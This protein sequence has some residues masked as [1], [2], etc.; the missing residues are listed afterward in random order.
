MYDRVITGTSSFIFVLTLL[1]I[2]M[3]LFWV[4][5]FLPESQ[6]QLGSGDGGNDSRIFFLGLHRDANPGRIH[7][8][9]ARSEQVGVSHMNTTHT[10]TL[11]H[12]HAALYCGR[13]NSDDDDLCLF[14][15]LFL[16][17]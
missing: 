16:A 3:F 13:L 4:W 6:V 11:I 8:L 10:Y 1:L 7:I 14:F 12:T 2:S 17:Y 9:Q 15:F 5:F